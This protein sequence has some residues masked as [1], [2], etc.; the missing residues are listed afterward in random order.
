MESNPEIV[1]LPILFITLGIAFAYGLNV[2]SRLRMQ[3]RDMVNKERLTAM[4]K[5]INLPFTDLPRAARSGSSL[6][7]GLTMVAIG[8][9]LCVFFYLQNAQ[10]AIGVGV[11]VALAGTANLLYWH[12]NGKKEW[13][14]QQTRERVLHEA[15]LAYLNEM[16]N[17]LKQP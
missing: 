5:G 3:D 16:T 14:Q 8:I 2:F 13:E 4:E 12:L 17:K 7:T 6:R 15:Q 1:I 9:G 11:I 10:D